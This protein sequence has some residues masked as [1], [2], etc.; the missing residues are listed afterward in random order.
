MSLGPLSP[1]AIGSLAS[2]FFGA[3][4]DEALIRSC[5]EATGGNPFLL[6]ALFRELSLEKLA[7]SAEAVARVETV[8]SAAVARSVV[9]RL[10]R[11]PPEA[12]RLLEAVA[13]AAAPIDLDV[14]A[15][16]AKMDA[17]KASAWADSLAAVDLLAREPPLRVLNPLVRRTVYA[18]IPQR[19]R[20]QLHIRTARSLRARGAPLDQ[21]AEHL[22]AAEPR[23]YE[24]VSR[25]LEEAANLALTQGSPSNAVRYLN[26]ALA[27]QPA[28]RDRSNILLVLARAEA[29][30]DFHSALEHLRRALECGADPRA[31]AHAGLQVARGVNDFEARLKLGP[32]FEKI[33]TLIPDEEVADKIDVAVATALLGASPGAAV[34]AAESLISVRDSRR[35]LTTRAQRDALALM[36][37]VNSGSPRRARAVEVAEMLR[38]AMLGAELVS[39]DPLKCEL[40]ASAVLALALAGE[41]QEADRYARHAQTI[42]RARS[43]EFADAQFSVTLAMSL[44]VQGGLVEAEDEARSALSVGQQRPWTR[45]GAALACLAGILLDQGRSEEADELISRSGEPEQQ[46]P[47]LEVPLLLEQRGRL[48]ALQG[49]QTEALADFLSAGGRAEERGIDS[50]VVT[51]W[52]SEAALCLSAEGREQDAGHL[53]EENLELARAHGASWVVGSALHVVASVGAA[54]KRLARLEH[55]VQLLDGSP[56]QVRLAGALIDLGRALRE[57]GA[58]PARARSALR[59]GTDIAFRSRAAPLLSKA[60]RELHLSGARPRRLA[61]SGTEALTSSE[62]RIVSLAVKGLTNAEIADVL[63]LAEKTVEGHLGHA[64]RKLGVRSRREL[65]AQSD[66]ESP[67][68]LSL[69]VQEPRLVGLPD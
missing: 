30:L 6:L 37:I 2:S 7:P 61:L 33:A 23:G 29:S 12:T 4:P 3:R 53:A 49:R 19:R 57:A 5:Q 20:A 24:W 44:A 15:E 21:L 16:I 25:T 27:E 47:A 67:E 41:F 46:L 26:R 55:A 62:R 52:R 17:A 43:L 63:F 18:E 8:T 13:V 40:W 9:A 10:A 68:H 69:A 14:I 32:M 22:V 45:S 54:D 39:E 38:H 34:T 51:S 50:P 64:Y 56:A 11:L 48:R 59:R 58:S 28:A 42:A 35:H 65:K 1:E 31:A 60:T 36:A 66:P